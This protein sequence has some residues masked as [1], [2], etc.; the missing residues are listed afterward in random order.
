[1]TASIYLVR[2]HGKPVYVGF[3]RRPIKVRWNI[4][5]NAAKKGSLYALHCAIRKHHI[6]A[7][8]VEC[9]YES[10][11][12][13]HTKNCME[14]HYIWLYQTFCDMKKGGYNMTMGGEGMIGY[15]HSIETLKKMSAA[16]IGRVYPLRGIKKQPLS[17]D[18]KKKISIALMGKPRSEEACKAISKSKIG[19]KHTEET[20]EK[21]RAARLKQVCPRSGRKHSEETKAKISQ[22]KKHN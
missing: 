1:M 3:T 17:E 9:L 13:E 5:C 22:S 15:R 14:Y 18:T 10:E 7:F 8:T 19:R 11:D 21:I 6:D 4:H 12:I 20:K 2:K 16:H